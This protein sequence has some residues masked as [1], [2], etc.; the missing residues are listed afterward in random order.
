MRIATLYLAA[1]LLSGCSTNTGT[2]L[3]AGTGLGAAIGGTA[4]SGTGALIGTAVGAV[5]GGTVGAILDQ[6]DRKVIEKSSPRTLARMD[7]GDP[8]TLNDVIRLSQDGICDETIIEFLRETKSVYS[9]SQTQIRRL[10]DAGVS[11]RVIRFMSEP[12]YA[13]S[14]SHGYPNHTKRNK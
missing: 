12:T 13:E 10:R 14:L 8:L 5:T 11:G 9:L 4:G 1:F 2:W 7:R 3:I 6:H